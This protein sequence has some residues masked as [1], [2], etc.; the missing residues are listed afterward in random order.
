MSNLL[1]SMQC[2][3][4]CQRNKNLEQNIV[5][6]TSMSSLRKSNDEEKSRAKWNV[7]WYGCLLC[8]QRS[9]STSITGFLLK[10]HF[11]SFIFS[12]KVCSFFQISFILCVVRFGSREWCRWV[13][14]QRTAFQ[15]GLLMFLLLIHILFYMNLIAN[16]C[17]GSK[18]FASL[19]SNF[20]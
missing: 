18:G 4:V 19:T 11:L 7:F 8:L 16:V 12:F 9:S 2:P 15:N 13:L 14:L 10:I 5:T 17:H 1:F 6:S 20:L 3:H